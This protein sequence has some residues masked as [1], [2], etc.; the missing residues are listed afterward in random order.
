MPIYETYTGC[1]RDDFTSLADAQK[2][3]KLTWPENFN[4][5]YDVIDVLAAEKPDKEALV[6]VS[7][8]FD[9]A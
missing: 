9:A 7:R 2:N 4:F 1:H 3:F 6:W 8:D 5:A